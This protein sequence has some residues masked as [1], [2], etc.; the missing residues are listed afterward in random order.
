MKIFFI[1]TSLLLNFCCL[2]LWAAEISDTISLK[3]DRIFLE[4]T[5][6]P[7][8]LE[9]H[10]AQTQVSIMPCGHI[11]CS[12]CRSCYREGL[13]HPCPICKAK[14]ADTFST[15]WQNLSGES[16]AWYDLNLKKSL[17]FNNEDDF[18]NI[19]FYLEE[20]LSKDQISLANLEAIISNNILTE[21][22]NQFDETM[23]H[24]LV[25]KDLLP[26]LIFD[27][28]PKIDAKDAQGRIPL[29]YAVRKK[30]VKAASCLLKEGSD[31]LSTDQEGMSP[32]Q[33][34]LANGLTD[35]IELMEEGL[36]WGQIFEFVLDH[37]IYSRALIALI[38]MGDDEKKI[39]KDKKNN[40]GDALI[41]LM[42]LNNADL[43][44]LLRLIPIIQG[45]D[46]WSQF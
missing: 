20:L 35:L 44:P 43:G 21:Q 9:D 40:G 10:Q 39:Y 19:L 22:R 3:V 27:L 8:C 29:Y 31:P 17:F 14:F 46:H 37:K 34:A 41:H 18:A 6:C 2:N 13:W 45:I 24:Q 33:M 23:L 16:V 26:K 5:A 42:A 32:Y 30:S 25:R 7:I 38:N 28:K 36:S 12:D 15:E 4:E 1:A 11:I